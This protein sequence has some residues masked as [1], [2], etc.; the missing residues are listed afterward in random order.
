MSLRVEGLKTAN[1]LF[2]FCIWACEGLI[3]ALTCLDGLCSMQSKASGSDTRMM[4]PPDWQNSTH[5][6]NI[7][8]QSTFLWPD[9]VPDGQMHF[10]CTVSRRRNVIDINHLQTQL[11]VANVAVMTRYS[12]ADEKFRH[13]QVHGWIVVLYFRAMVSAFRLGACRELQEW[14][15]WDRH[16]RRC[17]VPA[18]FQHWV[19]FTVC[20]PKSLQETDDIKEGTSTFS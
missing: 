15:R 13:L 20:F 5:T 17:R 2:L 19:E 1:H 9:A 4:P 6:T 10:P 7:E 12:R 16:A 18:C 14:H 3:S 8:I 11:L